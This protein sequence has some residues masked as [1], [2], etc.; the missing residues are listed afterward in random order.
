M[1]LRAQEPDLPTLEGV[2]PEAGADGVSPSTVVRFTFSK[3]MKPQQSVLWQAGTTPIDANRVVYSWSADQRT[4]SASCPGGWPA[5]REI[6]WTL[7]ASDEGSPP[8]LPRVVGFEDLGGQPLDWDFSGTF[9]TASANN[10]P[11]PPQTFTFT[12]SC[13]QVLVVTNHP[14]S[15]LVSASLL[16]SYQQT[17]AN[18]LVPSGSLP[19]RFQ[20]AVN[21]YSAS[22]TGATV[23]TSGGEDL[24][25]PV[26]NRTWLATNILSNNLAGLRARFPAGSYRFTLAGASGLPAQVDITL[27]PA[28]SSVLRVSNFGV[29]QGMDPSRD[30][31]LA[32]DSLGGTAQQ[33]IGVVVSLSNGLVVLRSPDPGCPGALDGRSTSFTIPAHVLQGNTTYLVTIH[34]ENRHWTAG[35]TYTPV[36]DAYSA[37]R[38]EF[39][40][41]TGRPGSGPGG[42]GELRVLTV[43]GGTLRLRLELAT[44]GRVYRLESSPA[45]QGPWSTVIEATA[46]GPSLDFQ[47]PVNASGQAFFRVVA[48]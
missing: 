1:T 24:P 45:P 48:R 25:L 43:A 37:L 33:T 16:M 7:L 8:F 6:E 26:L 9:D 2:V 3:P 12:N 11:E 5:N 23:R 14:I 13:G 30:F 19:S 34:F 20:A 29:A 39:S 21:L 40:L 31:V 42:A 32:W 28:P 10:W 41:K 46:P 22:A 35:D 27:P 17:D 38:T 47:A 4:L 18:T 36:R 44:A 15:G